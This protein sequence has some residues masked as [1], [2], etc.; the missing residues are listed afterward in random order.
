MCS[1]GNHKHRYQYLKILWRRHSRYVEFY[2]DDDFHI[3]SS[4]N[5]AEVSEEKNLPCDYK[6]NEELKNSLLEV[7]KVNLC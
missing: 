2:S 7:K 4:A 5:T 1:D 6:G 3:S